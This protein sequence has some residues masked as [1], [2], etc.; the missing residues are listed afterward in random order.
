[1]FKNL[2]YKT[3]RFINDLSKNIN[4]INLG[5][6]ITE[7]YIAINNKNNLLASSYIS[8]FNNLEQIGVNITIL[9]NLKSIY[10]DTLNNSNE[11]DYIDKYLL[12]KYKKSVKSTK[13]C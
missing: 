1:M 5:N 8:L 6:I 9:D 2:Y 11:L 7:Y 13:N 3:F 10:N 12:T 4:E